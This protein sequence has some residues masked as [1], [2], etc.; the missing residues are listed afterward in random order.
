MRALSQRKGL[1]MIDMRL[2]DGI[3]LPPDWHKSDLAP[4]STLLRQVGEPLRPIGGGSAGLYLVYNSAISLTAMPVKQPTGSA[5]QTMMCI[6][7]NANA[8]IRVIEWGVSFDAFVAVAP[9]EWQLV[10]TTAIFPTM[11]TA[12][13]TADIQSYNL[14][15]LAQNGATTAGFPL[16]IGASLSGFATTTVTEGSTTVAR[17]DAPVLLPPTAPFVKQFP[18]GREFEHGGGHCLRIRCLTPATVNAYCYIIFEA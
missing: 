16:Q 12:Y 3:W 7:P 8:N 15:T 10:D 4:Q 18:L 11:S 2:V 5:I 9:G 17:G 14:S 6:G 13:A 1:A